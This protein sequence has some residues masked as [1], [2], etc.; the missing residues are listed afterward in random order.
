MYNIKNLSS[1]CTMLECIEKIFLYS[2]P[3]TNIE[4]FIWANDQQNYNASWGL[5]LVVGEESKRLD[6]GLKN[7]H[8]QIP[9]RNIAGMRNFL[10]HDYRG[11][12]YDLVYEV[13]N[14]NLPALKEVLVDMVGK[15]D[16]DKTLLME[17]LESPYYRHIQ[18]LRDKLHD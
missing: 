2:K 12:D 6:S 15:V 13:I 17:V 8:P 4:D 1:I 18:Y 7:E 14:K 5:L 16:Y 3:F 9:W 10:A 11:I